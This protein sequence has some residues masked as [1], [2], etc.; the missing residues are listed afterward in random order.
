MTAP[1]IASKTTVSALLNPIA[2]DAA[3]V[4]EDADVVLIGDA[5]DSLAKKMTVANLFAQK[6]FQATDLQALP[7]DLT[8]V[9]FIA[10]AAGT[11][12]R[13]LAKPGTAC[14]AA[15]T[16]TMTVDVKINGATCLSALALMDAASTT[17]TVT[18]TV[19]AAVDDF[20]AGDTIT[21]VRD[22][23]VGS[24]GALANTVVSVWATIAL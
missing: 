11:I 5:T 10:G 18:G 2:L 17:T 16:E 9:S 1:T 13:V 12:K 15:S 23:T 8:S 24:G 22:Y 20:V 4:V 7:A 21:V 6:I 19:N 3:T 14:T